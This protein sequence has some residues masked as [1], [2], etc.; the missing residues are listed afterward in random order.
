[1]GASARK[2]RENPHNRAKSI[3]ILNESQ[4]APPSES[5]ACS[6]TSSEVSDGK[7]YRVRVPFLT[8]K[9]NLPPLRRLVTG[10]FSQRYSTDRISVE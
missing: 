3:S 9:P 10:L 7:W 1:M 8:I 5:S 2:V 6:D 4:S